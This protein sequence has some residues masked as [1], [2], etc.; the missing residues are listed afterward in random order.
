MLLPPHAPE[1]YLLRLAL[2]GPTCLLASA[3]LYRCRRLPLGA[4]RLL[5]A[6]PVVALFFYAPLL[7]NCIGAARE[8]DIITIVLV[9]FVLTWLAS[10]KALAW[11]CGRGPLARPWNL[12]QFCAVLLAP[13]TPVATG[14]ASAGSGHAAT[15]VPR[16]GR[17]GEHA[18][19]AGAMAGAFAA[20]A[21]LLA[22]G[23]AVLRTHP[24]LLVVDLLYTLGLYAILSFVMDGPAA[25]LSAAMGM[26]VA[27]HFDA[28]YLSTSL[29]DFWSR[30]WVG[31]PRT[32]LGTAQH[33]VH[34]W[35]CAASGTAATRLWQCTCVDIVR[36]FTALLAS[37]AA[38]RRTLPRATR[39]AWWSLS[40]SWKDGWSIKNPPRRVQ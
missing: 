20:K 38:R 1:T 15:P 16:R 26:A 13:I 5:A 2:L 25:G 7:F 10:Y 17:Q 37:S 11:A 33:G 8:P 9:E 27:P 22:V 6:L 39:C 35:R 3:W 14:S 40:P 4:P 21:A 36:Q 30:R 34:A 23:I 29:A 19:G 28:P 31:G 18:G 12:L 32:L 24:P